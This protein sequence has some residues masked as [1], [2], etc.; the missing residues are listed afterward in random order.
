MYQPEALFGPGFQM[1]FAATT[2]LVAVFKVV[3]QVDSDWLPRWAKPI[4][5]VV[6]SSL[7]AGLATAPFAAYHFNQIAQLGLIANLLSVPLMG[8]L[9]M[10]AAV[11][12]AVLSTLGFE[13]IGLWPMDAG[14]RW[15]LGVAHFIAAQDGS[16]R[17][18][19]TP[20]PVVMGLISLG[21]LFTVVWRGNVRWAGGIPVIL[22]F[23]VWHV[24]DRPAVLIAQSGSLIGVLTPEGRDVSKE[25]GE[26]FAASSWL[27][28]DGAP[29][30]QWVA[31]NRAGLIEQGR[32]VSAMV[33]G[34]D[35][36][37]VRGA[38]ALVAL[39]GCGGADILV[40]NQEYSPRSGCDVFDITRLRTTGAVAGW[41][42][43]GKLELVTARDVTGDR[44]WNT[45]AVQTRE[46]A[47]AT[48][49]AN[50][51]N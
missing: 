18:V 19:I 28:N 32:Q 17:H 9:V 2:A 37:N 39:D 5:A 23:A 42:V 3:R 49:I 13:M 8:V 24:A 35:V 36:V 29:V 4:G 14:L 16:L 33:A 41:I 22:G 46:G 38:T 43:D 15:I 51:R 1:S 40:T 48:L 6:V 44:L 26:G 27:E 21:A 20:P 25:R 30:D 12:A 50:A 47:L 45:R 11:L 34:Q 7:V 31:Y 10:P